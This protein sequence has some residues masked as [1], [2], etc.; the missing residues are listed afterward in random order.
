LRLFKVFVLKPYG[1]K[2]RASGRAVVA[3]DDS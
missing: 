2:H 3:V 1:S